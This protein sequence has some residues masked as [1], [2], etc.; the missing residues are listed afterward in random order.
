MLRR[1]LATLLAVLI[2]LHPGSP[3]AAAEPLPIQATCTGVWVIVDG[4]SL[5]GGASA[6]QCAT[7]FDTGTDALRSAGFE[8]RRSNGMIC[9]IDGL[10]A[11][12]LVSTQAYWSYWQAGRT[13]DGGYGPWV[14]AQLGPD[15]YEPKQGDAEGWAFGAGDPPQTQPP[16]ASSSTSPTAPSTQVASPSA[17]PGPTP[18]GD[19]TG[20]LVTA[21]IVVLGALAAG[22]WWWT[23]RRRS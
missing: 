22:G 5:A 9:A 2:A 1:L 4:G 6:T 16:A 7:T 12:C 3:P 13:A 19:P 17:T 10:P 15:S 8:V 11:S 23:S 14:Y 21:A 20:F 18:G